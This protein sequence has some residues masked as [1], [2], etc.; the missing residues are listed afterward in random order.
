MR[1]PA[2]SRRGCLSDEDRAKYPELVS[3]VT[4]SFTDYYRYSMSA[5]AKGLAHWVFQRPDLPWILCRAMP[6]RR[7]II[8]IVCV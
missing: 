4:D 3:D 8:K 1:L 2:T 5:G 6:G 7:I